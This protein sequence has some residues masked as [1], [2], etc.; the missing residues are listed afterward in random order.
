MTMVL[1]LR[2]SQ[3]LR[4]VLSLGQWDEEQVGYVTNRHMERAVYLN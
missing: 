1:S 4:N 3:E 2:L